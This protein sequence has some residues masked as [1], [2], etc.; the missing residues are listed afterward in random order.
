MNHLWEH[1]PHCSQILAVSYA[2]ELTICR[3][4]KWPC[5]SLSLKL[6]NLIPSPLSSSAAASCPCS[7]EKGFH[8]ALQSGSGIHWE[9]PLCLCRSRRYLKHGYTNGTWKIPSVFHLPELPATEPVTQAEWKYLYSKHNSAYP[10]PPLDCSH[11]TSLAPSL[12]P[13][14]VAMGIES[15]ILRG[16]LKH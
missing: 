10:H 2:H 7:A 5:A 6:C 3:L 12:A 1:S 4:L 11:P 9:S 16:F 8:P 15:S 13:F 14:I